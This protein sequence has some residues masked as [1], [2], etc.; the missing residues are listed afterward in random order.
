MVF[1]ALGL[2][3]AVALEARR[4]RALWPIVAAPLLGGAAGL[5]ADHVMFTAVMHGAATDTGSV[6]SPAGGLIGGR[7]LAF[8]IT[9]LLP[10]YSLNIGDALLVAAAIL[11]AIAVRL[12]RKDPP[13]RDGVRLFA[14]VAAS[15]AVV[16]LGFG[17]EAVPGLLVAFP[18]LAA[19]L[20]ALRRPTGRDPLSGR[21]L[22]AFV[23]FAAAVLATQYGTGGS[24]EWGGRYF[25]VGLPLIVPVVLLALRDV[26]GRLDLTT[27]R[28]ALASTVVASVTLASLG[29]AT[30]RRSHED[31]AAFVA[32]V[33]ATAREHPPGDG[34]RAVVVAANGAAGRFAFEVVDRTRWLT[35]KPDQLA[36]FGGRLHDLHIAQLT[37]VTREE[38]DVARLD[39]QYTVASEQ[40]VTGDWIIVVLHAR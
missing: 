39:A 5:L 21:L 26:G 8:I 12:A 37:F 31:V 15:A 28:I 35:V 6:T 40:H 3:V 4:R 32:A 38:S 29:V 30:L 20:A 34:D 22:V 1:V 13:E 24:G 11:G 2:A 18:L 7:V 27:Q 23:V 10:S 33:D 17:A 19:G 14:V 36:E 16:R 25:A 9:W